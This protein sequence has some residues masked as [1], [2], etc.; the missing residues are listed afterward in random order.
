M[1][2]IS[3]LVDPI[4]K[5]SKSS[6]LDGG[7]GDPGSNLGKGWQNKVRPYCLFLQVTINNHNGRKIVR[8]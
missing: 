3:I 5:R 1:K 8:I 7:Q 6:D 2:F 4:A